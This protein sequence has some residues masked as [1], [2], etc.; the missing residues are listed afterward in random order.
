MSGIFSTFFVHISRNDEV[1]SA[2]SCRLF[3]DDC[4]VSLAFSNPKRATRLLQLTLSK[5]SSWSSDCGFRFADKK[6]RS[7]NIP[8]KS[9]TSTLPPPLLHLQNFQIIL[10]LSTKFLGLT[11]HSNTSWTPHIKILKAKQLHQT[12]KGQGVVLT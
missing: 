5:I 4:S 12:T 9:L 3:A 7:S 8:Q 1:W 2:P 10:Q 11:F 6:N